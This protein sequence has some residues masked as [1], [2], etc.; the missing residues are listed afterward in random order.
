M[1]FIGGVSFGEKILG[2]VHQ[3]VCAVCGSYTMLEIR[4]QYQY[5]HFF[6]IPLF[7]WDV[8][9]YAVARCCG[10]VYELSKE[11]GKL[12]EHGGQPPLSP[13]DLHIVQ[14]GHRVFRCPACG[15][16]YESGFTFCPHCGTKL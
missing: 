14:S 4:K 6:F 2:T 10:T 13:E 1:F 5:F 11:K 8:H 15:R 12:F 9:Y 7:R 16:E 3:F